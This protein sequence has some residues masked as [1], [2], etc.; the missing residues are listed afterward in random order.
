M[1]WIT[2]KEYA[3]IRGK[4]T[5]A[6]YQLIRRHQKELKKHIRKEDRKTVIDE[7]GQELLDAWGNFPQQATA[8]IVEAPE[9]DALK[10]AKDKILR[11]TEEKADLQAEIIRL[12][13]RVEE[14]LEITTKQALLLETQKKTAADPEPG[15]AKT[16]PKAGGQA[17]E[18]T[19]AAGVDPEQNGEDP[20]E[21]RSEKRQD[22]EEDQSGKIEKPEEEPKP[23]K[24]KG[25]FARLFGF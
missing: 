21:L 4:T 3:T 12:H 15:E 20:E 8:A 11:L 1:A 25:F 23:E 7:A 18:I 14:L 5:Q 10:E 6:V 13:T 22:P 19:R 16:D 17:E 24:R 9:I 2:V